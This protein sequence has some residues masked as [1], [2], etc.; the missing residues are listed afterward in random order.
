LHAERFFTPCSHG[1]FVGGALFRFVPFLVDSSLDVSVFSASPTF[2]TAILTLGLQTVVIPIREVGAPRS[3]I[4]REPTLVIPSILKLTPLRAGVGRRDMTTAVHAALG[5]VWEWFEVNGWTAVATAFVVMLTWTHL[6][7]PMLRRARSLARQPTAS[8]A[9]DLAE[10]QRLARER[11]AEAFQRASEENAI[12]ARERRAREA[13]ELAAL[14]SRVHGRGRRLGSGDDADS[15]PRPNRKPKPEDDKDDPFR[16]LRERNPL[17][18][19]ASRGHQP[20]KRVVN[21]GG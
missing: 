11:Q 8:R 14:G 9:V 3:E 15:S 4:F 16:R 13:E 7:E 2:G 19:G 12:R 6:A 21:T 10:R 20:T 18:P 5:R 17:A 1:P